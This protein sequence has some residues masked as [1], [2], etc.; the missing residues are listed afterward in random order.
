MQIDVLASSSLG[1]AYIVSDGATSILLDAGIPY[2]ELQVK[3]DFKTN[4]VAACLV[5]HCHLD[6]ARAVKDLVRN[7]ID[8][9]GLFETLAMLGVTANYLHR[10]HFVEPLKTYTINTFEIMAI[11]MY[12]DC[13]CVGYM[14]HSKVTNERLFFATDTY[15]ITVNPQGIDYLI[16]EINYQKEIVNNLVNE[17]KME[18]SIRARLLFSHF[19]LSKAL[20]WLKR[21]DKSRLKRIYVCHLSSRNSNESEIKNTLI[22]NFGIPITICQS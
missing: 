18:A 4:E 2:K 13:P 14:L 3:S 21:I 10:T 15:K 8:V 6:H 19:E 7:A 12:H 1:N 5:T 17:G 22:E 11:T 16:L 20:S 9:Y